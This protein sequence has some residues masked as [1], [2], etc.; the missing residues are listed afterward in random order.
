MQDRDGAKLVLGDIRRNH[1]KLTH[2]WA[3]GGYRGKLIEWVTQF[4]H[5][6][7]EIVKRSDNVSQFK[8]VPKRWVSERTFGWFNRSRRLS[9]DY[10]AD[11]R[12]SETMAYTAMVHLML[13]RLTR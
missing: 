11:P 1:P 9:K 8:I 4:A 7:L 10:E 5:L 3:D 12:N 2:V 6:T 13:R